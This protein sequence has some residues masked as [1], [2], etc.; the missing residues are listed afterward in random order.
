VVEEAGGDERDQRW[1]RRPE[2]VEEA[3]GGGGGRRMSW[4]SVQEEAMQM[5]RLSEWVATAA[6]EGYRC[7]REGG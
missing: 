2:D 6:G 7:R 3:R 1:W 5:S 4:P